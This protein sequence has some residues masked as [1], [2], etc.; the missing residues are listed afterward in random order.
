MAGPCS[1]ESREQLLTHRRE[2][3][4]VGRDAAARRR[5]QAAHLAVRLPGPGR[6]RPG[7]A[8]RGPPTQR[9]ADHHRGDGPGR[10]RAAWPSTPTSCRSARATCRTSRCSRRSGRTGKP[11]H[12]QARPVGH[13]RRVADGRRVHHARGQPQRDPV[14]AR[15][16]HLRDG[17][18][19]HARPERHPAHQAPEPPAGRSPTRATAPGTATWSSRWRWPPPRRAPTA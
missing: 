3:R 4:G 19:Q 11:M 5:L 1:V 8:G 6:G 18:A 14:R 15:H 17:H 16:P 12:A 13:D 9:P 2:R 7:A 10:G